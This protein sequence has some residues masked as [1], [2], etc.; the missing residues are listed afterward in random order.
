MVNMTPVPVQLLQ[1]SEKQQMAP[2][3][4]AVHMHVSTH[5]YMGTGAH[6]QLAPAMHFQEATNLN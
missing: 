1:N 5:M 4:W 6:P 3:A 2:S